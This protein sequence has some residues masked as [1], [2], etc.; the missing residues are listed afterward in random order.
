M[1]SGCFVCVCFDPHLRS[2]RQ[3]AFAYTR[4]L[5]KELT[6]IHAGTPVGINLVNADTFEKWLFTIEVMGTSEYEASSRYRLYLWLRLIQPAGRKVPIDVQVRQHIPDICPCS[7]ICRGRHS[8][9]THSSGSCPPKLTSF[10]DP[11]KR[12]EQQHVYSNGHVSA[13]LCP[14]GCR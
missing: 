14:L 3:M 5:N 6:E 11:N 8:Q 9:G 13:C 12:L 10:A 1:G 7:A 4:R 2:V